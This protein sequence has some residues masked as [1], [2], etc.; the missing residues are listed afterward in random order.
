[1]C[2]CYIHISGQ[3]CRIDDK[4]L[5]WNAGSYLLFIINMVGQSDHSILK[6][7]DKRWDRIFESC[8]DR[9]GV[10]RTNFVHR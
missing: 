1:M 3:Q 4:W 5:T 9:K 7:G 10:Q 8:H 6:V 2:F